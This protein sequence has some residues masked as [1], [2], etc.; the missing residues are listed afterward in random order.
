MA[1]LDFCFSVTPVWTTWASSGSSYWVGNYN[2][3]I[4]TDKITMVR[5]KV[6]NSVNYKLAI[7]DSSAQCI[8][9]S[10]PTLPSSGILTISNVNVNVNGRVTVLICPQSGAQ[11]CHTYTNTHDFYLNG[12]SRAYSSSLV[13]GTI[14]SSKTWGDNTT[15]VIPI[16]ITTLSS[17]YLLKDGNNIKKYSS[18][19]GWQTIGTYPVTQTMFDNYGMDTIPTIDQMKQLT[20]PEVYFWTNDSVTKQAKWTL[21]D[22]EVFYAVSMNGST[23]YS[24]KS[25]AWQQILSTEIYDKGMSKAQI[26]GITLSQWGEIFVAGSL[27]IASCLKSNVSTAIPYIDNVDVNLPLSYNVGHYYILTNTNM[28]LNTLDW[29]KITSVATTQTTPTNTDVRYAFSN[30]N[31]NNWKVYKNGSWQ[32]ILL[33]AINTSGMT[34][35]EV[36]ALTSDQLAGILLFTLDVAIELISTSTSVYPSADQITFNYDKIPA[37]LLSS[38]ITVPVPQKGFRNILQPDMTYITKLA[39]GIAFDD[40]TMDYNFYT[41][42]DKIKLRMV[43][44]GTVIGGKKSPVYEVEIIN[45]YDDIDFEI[46]LR[47]S[48]N[49]VPADQGI[50]CGLLPDSTNDDQKT[51]IE[52]SSSGADAF[53]PEYPLEITIGRS[54]RKLFYIRVKPTLIT[55]GDE[56]FQINLSGRPL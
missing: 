34:K 42:P 23:Y 25:G 38:S 47:A 30:D 17:K 24:R 31:R 14:Y 10:D 32:N 13:V 56:T 46:T 50:N 2:M 6:P 3:Y 29:N 45:A 49:G 37:S 20:S 33:S 39:G 11:S 22:R 51:V 26:E 27:I 54:G 21:P 12:F 35:Q 53:N 43:Q 7:L 16:E 4:G 28:Q 41:T 1:V 44:I 5:A 19:S 40:S 55:A 36:E 9:I 15:K 8:F 48:Q 52:L 18:S